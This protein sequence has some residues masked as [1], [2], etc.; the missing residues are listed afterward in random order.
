MG[1]GSNFGSP[2]GGDGPD[3]EAMRSMVDAVLRE[4]VV[5]NSR[6]RIESIRDGDTLAGDLGFDSFAFLMALTDLERSLDFHLPLERIEELRALSFRELVTFV[7]SEK[8]RPSPRR[9]TLSPNPLPSR[10]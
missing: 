3:T 8:L 5:R 2:A 9:A 7:H 10:A 4:I 1:V 6:L